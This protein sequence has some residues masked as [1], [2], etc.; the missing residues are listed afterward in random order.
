MPDITFAA[1]AG[2]SRGYYAAP[3]GSGGPWPGVVVLHEVFGLTDDIRRQTDHLA[4]AGYVALAADLYPAGPT[5]RCIR[6]A[7]RDLLARRGRTWEAIDAA[8]AWLAARDECTGRV[9]VIGFCMGGG[10]AL[11]A[12]AR[13]DF[14]AASVNYGIVPRRAA[15]VLDGA[16]PIVAS[17]GG[18][19]LM[20][21]AAPARLERTLGELDVPH[22]VKAYPGVGHGFLGT[23]RPSAPIAVL[24]RI[25]MSYGHDAAAAADAWARI[26]GF[27]GEHLG[28]PGSAGPPV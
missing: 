5:L 20:L 8:R 3:A 16:C 15:A 23:H 10:F 9:G 25:T 26:L 28:A 18:R 4:A 11:V 24:S 2:E 17:Y 7:F 21:R 1:D 13:H 6:R 12:A 19:D 14:A 22:D 27:F